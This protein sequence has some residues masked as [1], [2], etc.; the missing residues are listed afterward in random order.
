MGCSAKAR[1]RK[2]AEY[3]S[4]SAS[5]P[6]A[7][8]HTSF[9]SFHPITFVYFVKFLARKAPARA[10]REQFSI[11]FY[12]GAFSIGF[13]LE[14]FSFGFYIEVF[15]VGFDIE[16]FSVGFISRVFYRFCYRGVFSRFCYRGGFNRF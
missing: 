5:C 11:R 3:L 2:A 8:S 16:E 15:S 1:S 14:G 9:A 6:P 4:S 10:H 13:Y 12:I 7:F